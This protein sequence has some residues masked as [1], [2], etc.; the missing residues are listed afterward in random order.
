MQV[1]R[2]E[3]GVIM[4]DHIVSAQDLSDF[5]ALYEARSPS[6]RPTS[7]YTLVEQLRKIRRV[8]EAGG[9]VHIEGVTT[10]RTWQEFYAWAHGRY[11]M[12]EDGCDAWIGDDG[13]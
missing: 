6:G 7:W 11:H 3:L 4:I 8:I 5:D 13:P 12:L 2:A 1:N 10:L 9:I